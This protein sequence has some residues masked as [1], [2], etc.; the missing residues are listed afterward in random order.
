MIK[1]AHLLALASLLIAMP[2]VNKDLM[3]RMLALFV[4]PITHRR[5]F[6]AIFHRSFQ[7]TNCLGDTEESR[8]PPDIK[9]ELISACALLGVA[10]G[11]FDWPASSEVSCTD[12][13][14]SRGGSVRTRVSHRLAQALYEM[15]ETR[16]CYVRLDSGNTEF[17]DMYDTLISTD[18]LA[19]ILVRH[20]L[21]CQ[22]T[23][24]ESH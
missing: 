2:L 13:T 22:P 7:W 15:T 11:H 14:P 12:A 20:D 8:I 18:P 10:H 1:R 21:P 4:H 3:R 19:S 17:T 6:L 5:E 16:G 9:D 24:D 23:R